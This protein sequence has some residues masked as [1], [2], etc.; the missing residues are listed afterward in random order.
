V[1]DTTRATPEPRIKVPCEFCGTE[2]KLA[3][4]ELITNRVVC[5]ECR[6]SVKWCRFCGGLPGGC[7]PCN[8]TGL[9]PEGGCQK[10]GRAFCEIEEGYCEACALRITERKADEAEQRGEHYREMGWAR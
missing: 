7:A 3:A 6:A 1:A 9:D 10:R 8:W 4:D 2:V 5:E